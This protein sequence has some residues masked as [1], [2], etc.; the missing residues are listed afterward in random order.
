ML[1]TILVFFP[2]MH[3]ISRLR[4]QPEVCD[5]MTKNLHPW[6]SICYLGDYEEEL[7]NNCLVILSLSGTKCF[8]GSCPSWGWHKFLSLTD[9]CDASK[10]F[11]VNNS[12]IFQAEVK[13]RS[14]AENF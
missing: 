11:L 4:L 2:F 8:T 3:K 7:S 10:G 12:L 5:L 6:D 9:L 1:Q 13:V 14:K